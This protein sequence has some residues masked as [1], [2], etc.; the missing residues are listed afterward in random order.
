M[1]A[2]PEPYGEGGR[3]LG[4]F[5]LMTAV[6]EPQEGGVGAQNFRIFILSNLVG[7]TPERG[8]DFQDL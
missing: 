7:T 6:P 4:S 8:K 1:I 5:G 3:F 2:V